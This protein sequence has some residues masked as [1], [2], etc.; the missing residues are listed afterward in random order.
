MSIG[1]KR[2]KGS[3]RCDTHALE[4]KV[5]QLSNSIGIRQLARSYL[6]SRVVVRLPRAA[7]YI[8]G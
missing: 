8:R 5:L 4:I 3:A 6:S 1:N 7:A 2:V